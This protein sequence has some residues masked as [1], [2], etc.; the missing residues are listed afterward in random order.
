VTDQRE[1]ETD[2]ACL[3]FTP[4]GSFKVAGSVHDALRKLAAEE[5]PMFSLAD[6]GDQLV[7]RS[8]EVA[9]I[10]HVRGLRGALG[11]RA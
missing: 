6:G 10:Q 4:G 9:A 8:S 2:S 3:I 5:W 7:I 1:T 11:F